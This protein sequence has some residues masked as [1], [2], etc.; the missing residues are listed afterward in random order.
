MTYEYDNEGR[1]TRINSWRADYESYRM[2]KYDADGNCVL[3]DGYQL[4]DDVWKHV[5]YVDYT[6][7]EQGR[8]LTRMNYNSLGTDEFYLGAKMVWEYEDSGVSSVKTYLQRWAEPEAFD[9]WTDDRY[10]YGADG[11]LTRR[12]LWMVPFMT[13]NPDDMF[14][15]QSIDYTYG[16]NGK[17]AQAISIDYDEYSGEE[18]SVTKDLYVY[19]AD[20]NVAEHELYIGI[21]AVVPRVK[22]VFRYSK[23][24]KTSDAMLPFNYDDMAMQYLF[25]LENSENVIE[26][27]EWWQVD[28]DNTDELAHI[29]DYVYVYDETSGVGR[30]ITSAGME[31]HFFIDG[32]KLYFQGNEQGVR[33]R[34]YD[35]AG[36]EVMCGLC[37]CDGMSLAS[38]VKGVY[39][40]RVDGSRTAFKFAR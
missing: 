15:Y 11:N 35:S 4:V 10:T 8:M 16:S 23:D 24:I 34:V 7:D 31:Q 33:V 39:L 1:L 26:T 20:D 17:L 6:F 13:M 9:I 5:Y 3:E 37:G 38:L 32:G 40:V 27:E 14:C 36:T 21:G 12:E 30:G 2:F 18:T 29:G 28:D 22:H 25:A 19:D